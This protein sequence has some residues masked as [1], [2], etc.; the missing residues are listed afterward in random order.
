[1]R[2]VIRGFV[3]FQDCLGLYQDAQVATQTLRRFSEKIMK[4]GSASVDAMLGVGGLIQVQREIQEQ[5]QTQ[6]MIMW[7][8]FAGQMRDLGKLVSTHAFYTHA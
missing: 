2:R 1:M 7:Q 5:Q 4:K 3:Q 6:F 8:G